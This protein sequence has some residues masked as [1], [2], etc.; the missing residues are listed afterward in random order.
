MHQYDIT[1]GTILFH[2]NILSWLIIFHLPNLVRGGNGFAKV[3]YLSKEYSEQTH[4]G[5][6]VSVK[7][8]KTCASK[9]TE[10]WRW[11]EISLLSHYVSVSYGKL[12]TAVWPKKTPTHNV[13]V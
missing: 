11:C 13:I 10:T 3:T 8:R 5:S 2:N 4:R 12:T 6:Q 9:H 1:V 7:N